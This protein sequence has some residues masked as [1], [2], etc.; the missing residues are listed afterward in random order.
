MMHA[1]LLHGCRSFFFFCKHERDF[2]T[3]NLGL[4]SHS[5]ISTHFRMHA[6][7]LH[8]FAV[9][10]TRG[11]S[12]HTMKLGLKQP[13][14]MVLLPRQTAPTTSRGRAASTT[15]SCTMGNVSPRAVHT[16]AY[17]LGIELSKLR[18]SCFH[19]VGEHTISETNSFTSDGE[20]GSRYKIFVHIVRARYGSARVLHPLYCGKTGKH[21]T[22]T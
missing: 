11:R 20:R 4:N 22:T 3:L 21:H 12:F 19:Y 2:H 5:F 9:F 16:H 17:G 8:G 6:C 13:G 18:V 15:T 1:Y 10:A 7:L 14:K